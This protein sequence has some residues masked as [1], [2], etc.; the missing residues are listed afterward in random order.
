MPLAQALTIG[1]GHASV[2]LDVRKLPSTER[3]PSPIEDGHH[4]R[5]ESALASTHKKAKLQPESS[6]LHMADKKLHKNKENQNG[7]VDICF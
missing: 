7:A 6:P 3:V 4:K 2:F 5:A 1:K